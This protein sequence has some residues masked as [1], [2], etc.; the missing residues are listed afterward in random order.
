MV[1]ITGGM[2]RLDRVASRSRDVAANAELAGA[3]AGME[4]SGVLPPPPKKWGGQPLFLG[5]SSG[6][7]RDGCGC[8]E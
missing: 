4:A 7:A 5:A 1:A 6:R 8:G 2:V 3:A